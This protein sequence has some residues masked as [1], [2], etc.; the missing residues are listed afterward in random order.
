MKKFCVTLIALALTVSLTACGEKSAGTNS[1]VVASS[2]KDVITATDFLFF[3]KSTLNSVNQQLVQSGEFTDTTVN[4]YWAAE[5]NGTTRGKMLQDQSMKNAEELVSVYKLASA[6]NSQPNE[7][8]TKENNDS[9]DAVLKELDADTTKA[10][11]A[12][13]EKFGITPD[14]MKE[15][16]LKLNTANSYIIGLKESIAV[17]DDEIKKKYDENKD[18]YDKVTVRHILISADDQKATDEEKKAAETKAN[19]ILKRIQDGEEIG[20]LAKEF[21]EDPGSKDKNGEYTFGKGEMV[22]EFED[23]AY[24]AKE[25]DKAVVKSSYGYHVMQMMG[26]SSFDEQKDAIKGE[27]Q[28]SKVTEELDKKIAEEKFDWK[29]DQAAIDKILATEV[30]SASEA[31]PSES[32]PAES[33][34]A[35]PSPSTT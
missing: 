21:S 6:A 24:A 12:F 20:A 7:K 18:S 11:V 15:T 17:T 27:I 13:V 23:W 33:A 34:P 29:V 10:N 35:S 32:A 5:E 25:G 1:A 19:D 30:E 16:Y 8:D 3:Y 4:D 14:E 2:G 22:K 9:I 26:R 28:T 31:E